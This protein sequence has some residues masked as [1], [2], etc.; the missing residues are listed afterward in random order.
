MRISPVSYL[1]NGGIIHLV[2]RRLRVVGAEDKA[3]A[4]IQV[5]DI[6]HTDQGVEILFIVK[7]CRFG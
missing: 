7:I 5:A 4:A 2:P 1:L 6:G 3:M